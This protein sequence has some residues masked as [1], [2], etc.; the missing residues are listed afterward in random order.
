MNF[1]QIDRFLDGMPSRGLPACSFLVTHKGKTVY[2]HSAGYADVAKTKPASPDDLYWVCS[3][4]KVTTC[5]AAMQLVESGKLRLDD[6]VSKYLPAFAELSVRGED[7][8]S[9]FPAKT[10]L[11][12]EHLFTMTGGFNYKINSE[13]LLQACANRSASTQEV[14]NALAKTPLDFEPGTHFQYSLC[15]DILAAVVEV[16]SGMRF[17]DYVKRKILDPLEMKDTGFHLPLE[18]EPRM[19]AMYRYRHGIFKSEPIECS[20][21]YCLTDN[22]D[23]GGA[24]LYTSPADQIKLMT[25]LACGGKASDGTVILRPET[26]AMMG[27]NRLC[28]SALADFMP[29]RLYGYG[30]GL[31]GRA[32]VNPNI[33]LSP[34]APGEFGW[35]GATGSFAL[36]DPTNEIAMYFGLHIFNCLYSY[37]NVHGRLRDMVYEIL[38][39]Q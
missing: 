27:E 29:Y 25:A 35:D 30:W 23:S 33:S 10:V 34:T 5:V 22:Y 16:I 3:I 18:L 8:K 17:A 32:H 26:I 13:P 20:N 31:C 36:V 6:P 4:T 7:K 2:N 37:Y 11:T 28:E 39:E 14:V 12:V 9:V 19:T 1:E 38:K 21:R 24:G 15:H